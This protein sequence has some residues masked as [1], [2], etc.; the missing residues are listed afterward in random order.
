MKITAIQKFK[1]LGFTALLGLGLIACG[2]GG[3]L[4]SIPDVGSSTSSG[5]TIRVT[6]STSAD[7]GYVYV[8]TSG[9]SAW[10]SDLTNGTAMTG[11]SGY[12][13]APG[14]TGTITGVACDRTID[15]KAQDYSSNE[16]IRS[17]YYFSCSSTLSW[18]VT[19]T[20]AGSSTTSS[21]TTSS[22]SG[23]GYGDSVHVWTGRNSG[24]GSITVR[25][26]GASKGTLGQ[27]YV[28]GS[29]T[30]C[31][32]DTGAADVVFTST[33]GS[34]TISAS[35]SNYSWPSA[36]KTKNSGVCL[37]IELL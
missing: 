16:A 23:G 33:A 13:I 10:G 30:T 32:V 31:G 36:F 35:N 34:H 12:K 22:S 9:T 2:G 18:T 24:G 20:G 1:V 25:W 8:R 7:I 14:E 21:S 6:N 26:D 15:L 37:Q 11:A 3:G 4:P 29:P 19:S 28:S 17:N 27:Y 5:G